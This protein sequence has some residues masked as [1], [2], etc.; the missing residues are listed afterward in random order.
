MSLKLK[1]FRDWG[2]Y[3]KIMSLSMV[4]IVITVCCVVFYILPRSEDSLMNEKYNTT[5]NV[6]EVAYGIMKNYG[7]QAD[8]GLISKAEA[9]RAAMAEI[10]KIRYD[11]DNYFWIN[12]LVPTMV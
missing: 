11:G 6:V 7:D 5:R 10:R 3:W 8:Q 4:V 9:Q 1:R 2:I 12:D